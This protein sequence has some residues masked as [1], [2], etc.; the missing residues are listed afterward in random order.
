MT[1]KKQ[2]IVVGLSGGVDSSVAAHLLKQQGHKVEGVFMQNWE[3]EDSDNPYCQATQDLADAR[4]VCDKLG[5]PLRTVQ[6]AEQYRQAVF[7]YFLDA[8]V[9]GFT[10][11][12]D[13]LC[14]TEIKFKAFLNEAL[15]GGADAIATGHYA[16]SRCV[17]GLY[18]LYKGSDATKDQSYFLHGLTQHQLKHSCFPL[19]HLEK[20]QVRKI[21]QEIGL[22]NYNKKDSTGICFI[23]ERPFNEFLSNYVL[24]QPGDI[25]TVE[26]DVIGRHTG[27]MFYTLGQRK[28]IGIGGQAGHQCSPWYVVKKET[29]RNVLVVAQGK[30]HQAL[31]ASELLCLKTHWIA[32]YPPE[33]AQSTGYVCKAKI[34]YRQEDQACTLTRVQAEESSQGEVYRVCFDV[35]QRAITPGQFVVFYAG[36]RCLGGG[37]IG[38]LRIAIKAP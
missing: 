9:A 17:E 22:M 30:H 18:Q 37:T 27:L 38:L 10:P 33:Q 32:G 15:A 7:S 5:I 23:G 21:A 6:F 24:S 1:H 28:G 4:A 31:Y 8:Y 35:P 25:E 13:V 36:D 26:G 16:Q 19:G 12:P 14:N 2:H 11:N 3:E 34:R 20:K 29:D